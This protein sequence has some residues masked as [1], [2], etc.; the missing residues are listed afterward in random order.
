MSLLDRLRAT[1]AA[2]PTVIR[3]AVGQL[4]S[5]SSAASSRAPAIIEEVSAEDTSSQG[6][7][8]TP[9]DEVLRTH[10][11][12]DFTT[13]ERLL[14]DDQVRPCF[15]Q[16]RTEVIAREWKVDPGGDAEIDKAAAIDLQ[17]QLKS[18][19]WDRTC[20]KMLSGLMYG[21]GVGECM[22]RIDEGTSQVQLYQVLVRRVARF[23]FATADRSLMLKVN[24]QPQSLP[25][26]KFWTFSCGAEN[27]DDPY[28]SA[29]GSALYWPVWMKRNGLK[30]WSQFLERF[31]NPTPKATV[32]P[33]TKEE[34]RNKLIDLL[35]R[36]TNGGRIVVPRGVDVELIQAIRSS[37]GDFE[38]F[39]V[40][41]DAAIAKIILLQTMT[42]DNGSS[43][44]QADVHH[45]VMTSGAKSDSDLLDE[46]FTTSVATWLTNWNFPG[47]KVPIVYRDFGDSQDLKAL[48][49]RDNILNQMGWRA[50]PDYI[51]D[52]YGDHYEYVPPATTPPAGGVAFAE[53]QNQLIEADGWRRVMGPEVDRIEALLADCRTLE[54]VKKK[55]GEL[56]KANPDQ[57]T[58]AMARM[59]F[60]ASALGDMGAPLD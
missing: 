31:A 19:G 11:G 60:T 20:F 36:I 45:K 22:F 25:P 32:P 46:S 34:D 4:R 58:E 12:G 6:I 53:A 7:V 30:F 9:R 17:N 28:G 1:A 42:T 13:Y 15:R 47:A 52:T 54:Q 56:A 29:L 35:G 55:L 43:L 24:G 44:A 38:Q 59:M 26:Q 5:A 27:D 41:L 14:D 10:G 51:A 3:D 18:I 33:G 16:R 57:L 50:K 8:L 49:E 39:I 21:F 48:A 23:A 40:R 37:G 2:A